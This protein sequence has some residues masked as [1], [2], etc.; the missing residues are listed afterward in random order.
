MEG[1]IFGSLRY[2]ANWFTFTIREIAPNW[3][4]PTSLFDFYKDLSIKPANNR[5]KSQAK[6]GTKPEILS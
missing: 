1:F 6:P 2:F 3:S 5:K 4:N